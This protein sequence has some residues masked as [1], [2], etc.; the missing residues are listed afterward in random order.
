MR[1]FRFGCGFLLLLCAASLDAL[2]TDAPRSAVPAPRTGVTTAV[3]AAPAQSVYVDGLGTSVSGSIL[4]RSRGG[5]ETTETMTLNG[6]V[7][8]NTDNHVV[9]GSN[10]ID[11]GAFSG[12]VGLPTVIQNSGNNV[13]IQTGVIVNVQFK[14]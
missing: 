9:T 10:L 2:A 1:T 11:G 6:S 4:A 7:D 8:H 3:V 5:I 13:L 14:P 12:A